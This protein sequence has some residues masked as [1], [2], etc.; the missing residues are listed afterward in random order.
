MGGPWAAGNDPEMAL[1]AVQ[2][3]AGPHTGVFE[4]NHSTPIR[5]SLTFRVLA[6]TD[7][8]TRTRFALA[9]RPMS[10]HP[11]LTFGVSSIQ[12]RSSPCSQ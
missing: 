8:R 7:A 12:R 1:L 9:D 3:M 10:I 2:I 11:R 5:P 6:H 4:N